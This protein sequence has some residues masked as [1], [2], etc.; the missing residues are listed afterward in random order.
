AEQNNPAL[1]STVL[2]VDDEANILASLKR[3]LRREGYEILTASNA[4][5]AFSLLAKNTVQVIVSDQRMPEMNGT[6]F[7]A[8]VK[9]LHPKTVRMVLSGYSEI[10]AVT[11]S[12]NK[13]AVYRFMLKPWKEEIFGALRHWRELYGPKIKT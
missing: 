5:E 7:L 13:G 3:T 4:M 2:F 6:E 1:R 9:T 8:R 10:S 11:D 12:I